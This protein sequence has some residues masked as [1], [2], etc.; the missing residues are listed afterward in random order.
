VH[1]ATSE[2]LFSSTTFAWR[3]VKISRPARA[4]ALSAKPSSRWHRF[5]RRDMRQPIQL[6]VHLRGGPECWVEISGRGS[7]GRYPGHTSIYDVLRDV[8][9]VDG[10]PA[11]S[12][13]RPKSERRRS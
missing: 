7:M 11:S 13:V 3:K 10:P 4:Q 6:T 1:D 8:N 12:L 9:N 5:S 2:Q